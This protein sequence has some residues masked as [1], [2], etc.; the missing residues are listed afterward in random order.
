MR[1]KWRDGDGNFQIGSTTQTIMIT[2]KDRYEVCNDLYAPPTDTFNTN[3]MIGSRVEVPLPGITN[4]DCDFKL[5][6]TSGSVL[7][8]LVLDV[9]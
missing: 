6:L 8:G 1:T 2:I 5:T 7:A 3:I 4:G 9:T